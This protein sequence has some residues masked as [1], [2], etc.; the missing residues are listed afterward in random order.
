MIPLQKNNTC[1]CGCQGKHT[2]ALRINK[3]GAI[4]QPGTHP[5]GCCSEK[6]QLAVSACSTTDSCC[7]PKTGEHS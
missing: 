7:A 1:R 2:P 3:I 6:P 5:A 4:A